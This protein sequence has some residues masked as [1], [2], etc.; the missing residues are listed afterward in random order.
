MDLKKKAP[1]IKR[2]YVTNGGR[3]FDSKEFN[4]DMLLAKEHF[5]SAV[6]MH[7]RI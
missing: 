4:F 6:M 3:S 7:S 2:V 5:D 1:F